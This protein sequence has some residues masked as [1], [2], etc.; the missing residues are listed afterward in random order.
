[1]ITS[2]PTAKKSIKKSGNTTIGFPLTEYRKSRFPVLE[3]ET[4][5]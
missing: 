4:D 1:M 3:K 2:S 5:R